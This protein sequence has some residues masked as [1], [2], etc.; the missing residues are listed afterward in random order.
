LKLI[1][2]FAA[3]AAAIALAACGTNPITFGPPD[4]DTTSKAAPHC[5]PLIYPARAFLN[6]DRGNVVVRAQVAADGSVSAPTLDTSS[7]FYT[8]DEAS[9]AGAG[10]CRF[11]P[12]TPRTV[13]L[14]FVWDIVAGIGDRPVSVV[15]I[16][17]NL[18]P[19]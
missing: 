1:L 15:G 18:Q 16:Q 3:P 14:T 8:L 13:K 4:L 19:K 7:T 5:P 17:P 11:D 2:K 9:V 6:R 12:G 10:F